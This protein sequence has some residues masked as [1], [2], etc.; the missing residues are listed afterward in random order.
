MVGFGVAFAFGLFLFEVWPAII[1][2]LASEDEYG[3]ELK[4]ETN[5]S[6]PPMFALLT[7]A[8]RRHMW[9]RRR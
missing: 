8:Y 7:S 1:D 4:F 5:F 9:A 3:E 2:R 6:T